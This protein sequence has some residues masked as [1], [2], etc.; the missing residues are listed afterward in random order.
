MVTGS[1]FTDTA[2]DQ[3][4]TLY[5]DSDKDL[6]LHPLLT[7]QLFSTVLWKTYYYKPDE[8]TWLTWR[9]SVIQGLALCKVTIRMALK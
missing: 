9:L 2:N 3:Q 7:A 4:Q 6:W 5:V 8:K 1:V